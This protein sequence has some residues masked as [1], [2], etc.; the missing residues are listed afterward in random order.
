MY[1][2]SCKMV[3]V[4]V[5]AEF[6]ENNIVKELGFFHNAKCVGLSM[7]PPYELKTLSERERKQNNWPAR[8]FHY[9]TCS[10]GR[11]CYYSLS[12]LLGIHGP[13]DRDAISRLVVNEDQDKAQQC[14]NEYFAIGLK[15]C[16]VR[17]NVL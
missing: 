8:N 1:K 2:H 10:E 11:Y 4:V 14:A 15:K 5:D 12:K 13:F 3:A 7:L 9:L 16:R 6:M 17:N